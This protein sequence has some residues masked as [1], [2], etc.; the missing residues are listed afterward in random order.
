MPRPPAVARCETPHDESLTFRQ[1]VRAVLIV[2]SVSAAYHWDTSDWLP[3]TR[4][5]NIEEA[6]P[7]DVGVPLESDYYLGGFD[8][9]S[10]YPPPQEEAFVSR[11][12]QPPVLPGEDYLRDAAPVSQPVSTASTLTRARPLFHPSQYLPPHQLPLGSEGA[13]L[14]V[15]ASGDERLSIKTSSVSDVSAPFGFEDSETGGSLD[16]L[17]EAQTQPY[18]QQTEV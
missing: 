11:D 1:F 7:G 3:T 12:R 16:S 10:E 9:D 5:S 17:E 18:T 2:C 8:V 4:L 13:E 14:N 6:T 15:F